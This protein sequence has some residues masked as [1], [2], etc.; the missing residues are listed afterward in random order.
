MWRKRRRR[1]KPKYVQRLQSHP[2]HMQTP[3]TEIKLKIHEIE[4]S[5]TLWRKLRRRKKSNIFFWTEI[6]FTPPESRTAYVDA[7]DTD[8]TVKDTEE[9]K[10]TRSQLSKK[11]SA[12]FLSTTNFYVPKSHRGANTQSAH[13]KNG[14]RYNTGPS[15]MTADSILRKIINI[16]STK[17]FH[18][19][20]VTRGT[21]R[22]QGEES[23]G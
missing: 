19:P 2:R 11:K 9:S 21:C 14:Q 18:V 17:N 15:D 23:E 12:K 7:E 1:L 6:N 8:R 13:T 4:K 22:H 16:S 20:R 10:A 5:K 3:R